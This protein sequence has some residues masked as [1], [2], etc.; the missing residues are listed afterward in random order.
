MLL[1][2]NPK[3]YSPA[4]RFD[5]LAGFLFAPNAGFIN[6]IGERG[7]RLLHSPEPTV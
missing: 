4:F 3:N 5:L 2:Q 7:D 1:A 6:A